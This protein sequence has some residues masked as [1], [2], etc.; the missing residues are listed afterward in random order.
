MPGSATLVQH[1]RHQS[2]NRTPPHQSIIFGSGTF[3]HHTDTHTIIL[4]SFQITNGPKFV[5]YVHRHLFR[6]CRVRLVWFGEGLCKAPYHILC[7]GISFLL[8]TVFRKQ[9]T[10]FFMTRNPQSSPSPATRYPLPSTLFRTL[11][12]LPYPQP[13]TRNPLPTTRNPQQAL[14]KNISRVFHAWSGASG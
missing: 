4:L 1:S 5:Q 2:T 13:A 11:Y 14:I 3:T 9:N 6:Y 7:T 8:H 10:P 12:P